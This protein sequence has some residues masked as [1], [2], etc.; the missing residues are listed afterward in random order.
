VEPTREQL[1]A[2]DGCAVLDYLDAQRRAGTPES[3]G[4]IS[5]NV[6]A[7]LDKLG[8]FRFPRQESWALKFVQC[9]NALGTDRL[10]VT[11]DRNGVE[12]RLPTD[13]LPGLDELKLGLEGLLSC[14]PPEEHLRA[15]ILALRTRAGSLE[16]RY[17]DQRWDGRDLLQECEA[18]QQFSCRFTNA[19]IKGFWMWLQARLGSASSLCKELYD[20]AYLS[21]L[22]VYLDGREIDEVPSLAV[23][24]NG[25]LNDKS[26]LRLNVGGDIMFGKNWYR[27]VFSSWARNSSQSFSYVVRVDYLGKGRREDV[28][29]EWLRDGI[30]VERETHDVNST[31]GVRVRVLLPAQGLATDLSGLSLRENEEFRWRRRRAAFYARYGLQALAR[32]LR[33]SGRWHHF[34]SEHTDSK[35]PSHSETVL[36]EVESLRNLFEPRTIP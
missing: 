16:I 2:Q 22:P 12:V 33:E 15:A 19:P 9:A 21:P 8:R 29:L 32:Q 17:R 20:Y 10:R 36:V 6:E 1:L 30:V 11:I 35:L 34:V 24:L 18:T 4:E 26:G 25:I 14:D 28:C 3:Q 31:G 27:D 7:A 13:R 23:L 5:V